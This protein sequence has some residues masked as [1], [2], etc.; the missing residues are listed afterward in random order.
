MSTKK[1]VMSHDPLAGLD[2]EDGVQAGATGET[3]A[4]ATVADDAVGSATA[5]AVFI[6]PSSLTIAEVGELYPALAERMQQGGDFV[7]DCSGV[8]AVDG[9]GLQLLA[10]LNKSAIEHEVSL[11]WRGA[12][13]VLRQAIAE[14]GLNDL[15]EVA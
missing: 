1:P 4:A 11:G 7:I 6:L 14:L 15:L 10:A 9:A 3:A 2:S 12:T 8:D 13:E 5:G